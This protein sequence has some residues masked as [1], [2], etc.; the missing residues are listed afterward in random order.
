MSIFAVIPAGGKGIRSGFTLPKQYLKVNG[1]ELIAYT[2]EIFQNNRSVDDITVSAD[3]YYFDLLKNIKKKYS[4]SKLNHFIE[5]GNERQDSVYNAIKSLSALP[6]DIV[7]VHDAARPLLPEKVLARAISTAKE[8][9]NAVVCI[10]AKDTLIRGNIIVEKYLDREQVFYVQT[11]QL[12]T[13]SVLKKAFAKAYTDKFY[14]TDESML[15]R[16]LR[17]KINVADGS[18]FNFKVTSQEDFELLTKLIGHQLPG[19]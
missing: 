16:R 14:G 13:Y 12:F 1:K 7:I 17:E 11:P 4:L 3:P 8:K 18:V 15:V 6:N 2:F 5:G 9:G 10:K 19:A